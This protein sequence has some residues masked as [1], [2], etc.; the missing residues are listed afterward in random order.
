MR[1]YEEIVD[2]LLGSM[3]DVGLEPYNIR[4]NIEL[5]SLYKEFNCNCGVD[6]ANAPHLISA[7]INFGWDSLLSA[8]SIYGDSCALYHDDFVDCPHDESNLEASI[9]LEISYN[10][11]IHEDLKKDTSHLSNELFSFFNKIME[12]ENIPTIHWKVTANKNGDT[13]IS[14]IKATHYWELEITDDQN[15]FEGIF[16]EVKDVLAGLYELPFIKNQH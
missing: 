11:E 3:K 14:A 6:S 7:Q 8:T 16:L 10:I 9:E 2:E 5:R 12:H 13:Y 4:E 15:D 1:T